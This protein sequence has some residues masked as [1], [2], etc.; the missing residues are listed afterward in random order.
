M[1]QVCPRA[2]A[3]AIRFEPIGKSWGTDGK[4]GTHIGKMLSDTIG[5]FWI[6]MIL[7]INTDDTDDTDDQPW[8]QW[9]VG[10]Q[11]FC[12]QIMSGETLWRIPWVSRSAWDEAIFCP[13]MHH[14][15]T[16]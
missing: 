2:Q 15:P 13:R 5:Y 12:V 3:C 6:L 1:G 16:G 8:G 11:K 10:K 4:Y 7:M 9:D 14:I